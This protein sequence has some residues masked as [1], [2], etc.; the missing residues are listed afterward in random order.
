MNISNQ[1]DDNVLE[2]ISKQLDV[3]CFRG[4]EVDVLGRL[5]KSAQ[6]FCAHTVVRICADNPF[7]DPT[8]IDRLVK[9]F[10]GNISDYACNHQINEVAIMLMVLV[11]KYP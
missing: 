1:Q 2:D 9:E 3:V 6:H 4:S 10:R 8:E 5:A 11:Q 7:I